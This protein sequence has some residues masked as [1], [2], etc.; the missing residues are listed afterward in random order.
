MKP[1]RF[2]LQAVQTL[3]EKQETEAVEIY[4]RACRRQERAA[5]QLEEV[6]QELL[7]TQLDRNRRLQTNCRIGEVIQIEGFLSILKDRIQEC[8]A[9]WQRECGQVQQA[10]RGMREARQRR[11]VIA[12]WLERDRQRHAAALRMHEQKAEDEMA[13]RDLPELAESQMNLS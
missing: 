4:A 8:Q 10:E 9:A 2:R 11:E 3:R 1:F 7:E 13:A 5:V 6:R 12:K